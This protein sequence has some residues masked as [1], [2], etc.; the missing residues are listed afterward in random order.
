MHS[1]SPCLSRTVGSVDSRIRSSDVGPS[2]WLAPTD[3]RT[4]PSSFATLTANRRRVRLFLAINLPSHQRRALFQAT[5]ALREAAPTLSWVR[6]PLLHLTLKFL[7]DQ[8]SEVAERV[9][10][11]IQAVASRHREVVMELGGVGAFPNFRRP[12][13]VW[14]G[15]AAAPKLE[16]LHHEL[17]AGAAE[18]GFDLDGRPFRPHLT[19]A[20]VKPRV[21][22]LD[23]RRA[24]ARAAKGIHFFD[25]TVVDAIDLMQSELSPSGATYK[26]LASAPL[27]GA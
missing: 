22:T 24:L 10:T 6:E 15:V 7:G 1:P 25:E 26:V 23:M 4:W 12:R 9:S 3:S 14:M 19:L 8:P 2:S 27:R 5:T 18:L 21:A 17:E 16:L 11:M 13:V 20:R